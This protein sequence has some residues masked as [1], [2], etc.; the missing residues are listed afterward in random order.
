VD[1]FAHDEY[2]SA[3]WASHGSIVAFPVFIIS[4]VVN[5]PLSHLKSPCFANPKPKTH[6]RSKVYCC[7][8][9]EPM[10]R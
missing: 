4:H 6:D 2:F 3:C 10:P 7:I 5:S 8:C 9:H 1:E